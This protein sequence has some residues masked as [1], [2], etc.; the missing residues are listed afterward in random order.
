MSVDSQVE[1]HLS[2]SPEFTSLSAPFW[3]YKM[4]LSY[5]GTHFCGWQKQRN[6]VTNQKP[7]VQ[8]TLEKT[9]Q[10]M[11][12]EKVRVVGS[13]RTDSGVHSIGQVSHFVLYQKKWDLEILI[14][15]L[16][17]LLPKSIQVIEINWVDP[18]FHAQK[19]TLKKQYSYYFQQ[20]VCALPHLEPYTWWIRK[21]LNIEAMS[22]A[23][24]YL[25]GEHDFKPFRSSG[26]KP[27]PTVRTILEAEAKW[28]P[29][30]F[31]ELNSSG[32]GLVR[33][34]LV[35]NGFLKQMVRGIAGTLLQVGE[36]RRSPQCIQEILAHQRREEVGPTAPA[37]ALWQEKVSYVAE[38]RKP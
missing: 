25:V 6:A 17:S 34:R 32:F 29:I 16:N 10:R 3:K 13:G 21:P 23:L 9:L 30:L 20:G 4:K 22:E 7:S 35:S 11:T 37:K 18:Q 19:S 33:I 27:G 15:G 36:M 14:R 26:A 28:E 24:E 5:V 8:E 2:T 38:V 31:P 1:L 12:Q